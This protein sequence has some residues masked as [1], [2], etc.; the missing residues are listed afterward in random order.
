MSIQVQEFVTIMT[1]DNWFSVQLINLIQAIEGQKNAED[2][3]GII[4]E[5]Q[6]GLNYASE[7]QSSINSL[8]VRMAEGL[9]G[10]VL[11]TY[12]FDKEQQNQKDDINIDELKNALGQ[13][14]KNKVINKMSGSLSSLKS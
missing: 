3:K 7:N 14:Q 9:I 8:L 4:K 2:I 13:H 11:R 6:H 10:P 12:H 5:I 1:Y